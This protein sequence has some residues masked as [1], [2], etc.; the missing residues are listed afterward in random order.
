MA[1]RRDDF[2]AFSSALTGF[3]TDV[4]AAADGAAGYLAIADGKTPAGSLDA[5]L[6]VYAGQIA[7]GKPAADVVTAI[8]A[9]KFDR[10]WPAW[11][12]S[13]GTRSILTLWFIGLWIDD[14]SA[15]G[16][17]YPSAQAYARGLVWLAA[18]AHPV[19]V[20]S[21]RFGYWKDPPPALS[22]FLGKTP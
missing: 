3:G 17:P 20:S 2:L 9:G 5:L 11:P 16:Q 12:L 1:S 18:Q 13:A 7:T 15:D 19:G 10:S 4:L 8:L 22:E 6:Q 21:F 14:K